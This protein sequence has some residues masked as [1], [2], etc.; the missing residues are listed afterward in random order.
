M[1]SN[2]F[3]LGEPGTN[4]NDVANDAPSKQ[5]DRF[6]RFAV[7]ERHRPGSLAVVLPTDVVKQ[8]R[9]PWPIFRPLLAPMAATMKPVRSLAGSLHF[10]QRRGA[11]TLS[12][13]FPLLIRDTVTKP[14]VIG[15]PALFKP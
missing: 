15:V 14:V 13:C 12:P 1:T 11:H 2:T 5:A 4:L 8:L 3:A 10:H 7:L 9:V 6:S